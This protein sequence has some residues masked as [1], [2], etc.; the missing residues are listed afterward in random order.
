MKRLAALAILAI[1][2]PAGTA[3]AHVV[4]TGRDVAWIGIALIS[5]VL[6][7]IAFGVVGNHAAESD[8]PVDPSLRN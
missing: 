2:L 4:D 3:H 1:L 6:L 8:C 7:S 5:V